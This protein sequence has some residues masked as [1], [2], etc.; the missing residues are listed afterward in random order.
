MSNHT[1]RTSK[2][3]AFILNFLKTATVPTRVSDL[4]TLPETAKLLGE[5]VTLRWLQYHARF[6]KTFPHLF[7]SRRSYLSMKVIQS[8]IVALDA[9]G[10][11]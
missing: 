6:Y 7:L 2:K 3:Q 1:H 5:G 4:L 11:K 9:E 10:I 8:L